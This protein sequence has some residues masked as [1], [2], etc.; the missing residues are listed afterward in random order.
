LMFQGATSGALGDDESLNE[1]ILRI[2]PLILVVAL[3][4]RPL[5]IP[6]NKAR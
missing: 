5:V 3:N 4:E 6:N 2:Q 1:A